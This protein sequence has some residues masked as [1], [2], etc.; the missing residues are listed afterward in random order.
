MQNNYSQTSFDF[1]IP[2]ASNLDTPPTL[3]APTPNDKPKPATREVT[4]DPL[5]LT[6]R[7]DISNSYSAD[8]IDKGKIRKPFRYNGQLY[9]TTS[10]A[11]GMYPHSIR[12]AEAYRLVPAK[13]FDGQI[14]DFHT[15]IHHDNGRSAR[16][17][18]SGFYHGIA[19]THQSRQ[20]VLAGPPLTFLPNLSGT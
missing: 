4:V 7:G 10:A 2:D 5:R 6:S 8:V 14:T 15:K 12:Q 16:S 9:T 13:L 20:Y 3:N 17:G 11:S 19:I 18:P 1:S